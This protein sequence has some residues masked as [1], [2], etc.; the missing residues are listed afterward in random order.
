M[1]IINFVFLILF[2]K[3]FAKYDYGICVSNHKNDINF[4][5]YFLEK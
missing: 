4:I 2:Y 5:N 3:I 1:S